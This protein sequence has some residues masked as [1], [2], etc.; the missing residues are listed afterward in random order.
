MAFHV[1]IGLFYLLSLISL[2][3]SL[4]LIVCFFVS[5]LVPFRGKT[6]FNS[7][8]D[9]YLLGVQ[10]NFPANSNTVKGYLQQ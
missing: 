5:E 3:N 9:W 4:K 6:Q 8:P 1:N 2:L 10:L 7:H